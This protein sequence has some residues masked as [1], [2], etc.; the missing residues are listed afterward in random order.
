[1]SKRVTGVARVCGQHC[2]PRGE[3]DDLRDWSIEVVRDRHLHEARRTAAASSRAVQ[4]DIRV[5]DRQ[6]PS[7]RD[8]LDESLRARRAVGAA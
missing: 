6:A 1:M 7:A 5:M 8:G 4:R 3:Q 2:P